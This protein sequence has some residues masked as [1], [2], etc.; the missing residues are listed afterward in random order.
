MRAF[1]RQFVR[2]PMRLAMIAIIALTSIGNAEHSARVLGF[3][4]DGG[5]MP[6]L[7][8]RAQREAGSDAPNLQQSHWLP[9]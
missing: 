3:T 5:E 1:W 4:R 8:T 2:I 9:R 6:E 7:P